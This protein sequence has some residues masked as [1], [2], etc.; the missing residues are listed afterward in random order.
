M[1]INRVPTEVSGFVNDLAVPF[2]RKQGIDIYGVLPEVTQLAALTV[3][4]I[5]EAL[6]AKVLTKQAS[7]DNLVETLTV[8][9]MTADAAR[10]NPNQTCGA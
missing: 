6:N 7:L 9:A 2:L 1:V 10:R 4:E 8:G 5:V 3:E